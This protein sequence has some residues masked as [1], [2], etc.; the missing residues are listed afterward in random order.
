MGNEQQRELIKVLI[1]MEPQKSSREIA[2]ISGSSHT[3]VAGVRESENGQEGG[4]GVPN[5]QTGQLE[6]VPN[7]RA[8]AA[9]QVN[10]NA[11]VTEIANAAN[12]GRA[13]AHRAKKRAAAGPESPDSQPRRKLLNDSE[14]EPGKKVERFRAA[15]QKALA[16]LTPHCLREIEID[17]IK[18]I[19]TQELEAWLNNLRAGLPFLGRE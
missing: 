13:T 9:I 8:K 16:A 6:H 18:E 4:D 17:V 3:T 7:E 19:V 11:S 10:P 12:V 1:Q 15:F 5:G 2:R 14:Q